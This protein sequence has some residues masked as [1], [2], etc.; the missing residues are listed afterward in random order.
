MEKHMYGN[1]PE[2]GKFSS[3]YYTIFNNHIGVVKTRHHIY[4]EDS[5]VNKYG[6]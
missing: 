1:I 5:Y 3:G 4:I 6:Y 2:A